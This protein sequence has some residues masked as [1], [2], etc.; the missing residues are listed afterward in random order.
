MKHKH[1]FYSGC[2]VRCVRNDVLHSELNNLPGIE[3]GQE[4]QKR[5]KERIRGGQEVSLWLK[6]SLRQVEERNWK[7]KK[8]E[9]KYWDAGKYPCHTSHFLQPPRT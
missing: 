4:E 2:I 3:G 6:I 1:G 8:M 7:Y 5:G 9:K